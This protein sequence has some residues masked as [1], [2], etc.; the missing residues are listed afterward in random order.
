MSQ[1]AANSTDKHSNKSQLPPSDNGTA[2]V[3]CSWASSDDPTMMLYHDEEWGTPK[4]DDRALFA[5]LSLE[6][7]QSGL[8]WSTILHK[9]AAISQAFNNFDVTRVAA[10]HSDVESLMHNPG[11]IRN[12]RKIQAIIA[13]AQAIQRIE[14]A[15]MTFAHYIWNY[16]DGTPITN[17][18]AHHDEVPASTAISA[19]MSTKMKHDGF[20]FVGPVVMY[21][22]MQAAGLVNDHETTCFRYAQLCQGMSHHRD[23]TPEI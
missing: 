19:A 5:L 16:V 21:S 15:G 14:D 9:R 18:R 8:S 12:R 22:F 3:R 6:L 4:R 1:T 20:H 7:M 11:I 23:N 13:N 2:V 17:H 10:M